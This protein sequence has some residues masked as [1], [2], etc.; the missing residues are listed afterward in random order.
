MATV[1]PRFVAN[2]HNLAWFWPTFIW[3]YCKC[4]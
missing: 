1:V 4:L 2:M 3:K